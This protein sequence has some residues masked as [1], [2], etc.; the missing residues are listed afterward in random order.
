MTSKEAPTGTALRLAGRDALDLLDRIGTQSLADLPPGH[1]RA[2][3]FCDFRGRLLHRAIVARTSDGAVWLV[4]HDAPAAPLAAFLDRHVFREDVQIEDRTPSW[5]PRGITDGVGL[6]DETIVDRD[7]VPTSIQIGETFGLILGDSSRT[8]ESEA[9]R[10]RAGRPAHGHEIV[11][12]FHPY[13]VGLAHEVHLNK[14]CYTGQEVLLRLVTYH[15]VRRALARVT[16]SGA[17]PGTPANL[18]H[19]GNV[20]GRLTS[21]VQDGDGWIGLAIAR[22]DVPA[23]GAGVSVQ[24]GAALT[25]LVPLAVTKPLGRP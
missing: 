8:A 23:S 20:V 21:A 7:G 11:D 13:E 24:D 10:I 19:D 25:S 17:A 18:V 14:G 12:E 15:G 5:P 6:P 1:A 4:R 3:L 16:G 22:L 9:E 2:T